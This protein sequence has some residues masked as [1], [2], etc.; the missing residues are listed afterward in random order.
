MIFFVLAKQL[1]EAI[2]Q[3]PK[4]EKICGKKKDFH[5]NLHS[6]HHILLG[7]R[8]SFIRVTIRV[9]LGI[10]CLVFFVENIVNKK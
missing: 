5:I 4:T 6:L 3:I 10:I 2:P 1:G 8:W 7:R 9:S